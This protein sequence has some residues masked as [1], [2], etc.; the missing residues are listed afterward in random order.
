VEDGE[1]V[2]ADDA[3]GAGADAGADGVIQVRP[4]GRVHGDV[5]GEGVEQRQVLRSGVR[6]LPHVAADGDRG[7]EQPGGHDLG[8]QHVG[9]VLGSGRRPH[10]ARPGLADVLV[11]RLDLGEER[12]EA[13]GKGMG[14][15]PDG[16]VPAGAQH[17]VG[18]GPPHRRVDPMPRG[19]RVHEVV[20]T[21]HPGPRLE[22][23]Y[24]YRHFRKC[25][26]PR[27]SD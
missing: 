20:R 27:P 16:H 10:V 23:A 19:G 13:Q 15:L 18:L 22:L 24:L 11:D 3:G 9:H 2:A 6:L 14:C 7:A 17:R 1:P 12:V 4:L 5:A 25:R 8:R 26:Q 21:R